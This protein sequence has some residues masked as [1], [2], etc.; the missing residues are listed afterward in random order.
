MPYL[1]RILTD[2]KWTTREIKDLLKNTNDEETQEIIATL[3]FAE[4]ETDEEEEEDMSSDPHDDKE[5]LDENQEDEWNISALEVEQYHNYYL[6]CFEKVDLWI[7]K[8][9][10][11][12]LSLL[13]L[14]YVTGGRKS[15]CML[16]QFSSG[17]SIIQK[18]PGSRN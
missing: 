15:V 18:H 10:L 12:R 11:S 14:G 5:D 17:M 4:E 8:L 13:E 2:E 1:R 7:A 9:Q 3:G 16:C 6:G